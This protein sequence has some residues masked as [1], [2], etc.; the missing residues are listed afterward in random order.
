[1]AI[2][3]RV[4]LANKK[5][6]KFKGLHFLL[7]KT[8]SPRKVSDRTIRGENKWSRQQLA[9]QMKSHRIPQW[10]GDKTTQYKESNRT[11][12]GWG[13]DWF[14]AIG[15]SVQFFQLLLSVAQ[16]LTL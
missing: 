6:N 5:I 16:V 7:K 3:I 11:R 14:G 2:I 13:W 1:L 4:F 9:K 12:Q 15:T 8:A 10:Q